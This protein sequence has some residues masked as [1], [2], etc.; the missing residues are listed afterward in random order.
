M[1]S[2]LHY[3]LGAWPIISTAHAGVPMRCP[4][5]LLAVAVT[6]LSHRSER[7]GTPRWVSPPALAACCKEL[8]TKDY[9]LWETP[10]WRCLRPASSHHVCTL[11]PPGLNRTGSQAAG[12]DSNCLFFLAEPKQQES[13]FTLSLP[14][15]IQQEATVGFFHGQVIIVGLNITLTHVRDGFLFEW[16]ARY[17]LYPV[18]W[19]RASHK[20]FSGVF[21]IRVWHDTH[22]EGK[23]GW[24]RLSEPKLWSPA[25][26]K[27]PGFFPL[28]L[29]GLILPQVLTALEGLEYEIGSRQ[30]TTQRKIQKPLMLSSHN[31]SQV[32]PGI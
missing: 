14:S 32:L 27:S 17:H 21:K 23:W 24:E 26:M 9:G 22:R 3:L 20:E 4:E 13:C 11:T 6:P 16:Q 5:A 12:D 29:L 2:S 7:T 28:P 30:K 31:L 19:H 25:E 15:V 18:Q 1:I 10:E 8:M